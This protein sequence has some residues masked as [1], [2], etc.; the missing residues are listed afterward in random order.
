MSLC[1]CKELQIAKANNKDLFILDENYGWMLKWIE[2]TD[3]SGYT[4]VHQYA[5]AISFCPFCGKRIIN[6]N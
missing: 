3:E 4:Q 6:G 5:M 2:L 1:D